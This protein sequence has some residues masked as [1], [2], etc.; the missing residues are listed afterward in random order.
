[1]AQANKEK[2]E[3][4]LSSCMIPRDVATCWNSTYEMLSF[5]YTYCNVYN[6]LTAN[7]DMKM[8]HYELSDQEW[9]IVNQLATVLKVS[10]C[11]R[12]SIKSP[13]SLPHRFS[14]MR[15]SSSLT[16]CQTLRRSFQQWTTSIGTLQRLQKMCNMIHL[17]K[18]HSTSAG[19]S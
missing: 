15:P 14:M 11:C 3:K 12:I 5:A 10:E 8:R 13:C 16:P 18:L 4:A 6:E 17:S 2:G 19:S 1:M 7:W 9:Q